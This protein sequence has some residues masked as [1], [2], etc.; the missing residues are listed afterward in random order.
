MR[1]LVQVSKDRRINS[2]G[3]QTVFSLKIVRP[4]VLGH[5]KCLERE[6]SQGLKCCFSGSLE[7]HVQT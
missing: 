2:A 6:H 4:G 3:R 5:E 7:Q 1:N